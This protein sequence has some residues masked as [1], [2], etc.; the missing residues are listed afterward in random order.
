MG[1][2]ESAPRALRSLRPAVAPSAGVDMSDKSSRT[3]TLDVVQRAT[4]SKR[5][6][7]LARAI[8]QAGLGQFLRGQGPFTIFAPT[9]EA[10]GKLPADKREALLGDRTWLA[11]VVAHH[12][13]TTRVKAPRR[14]ASR[15]A[16]PMYGRELTI[17][18]GVDA[19]TVDDARLV[20]TGIRATNGVIHAIDTVLMPR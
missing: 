4:A 1:I 15:T 19:F 5:F 9:D 18:R 6:T 13:V 8:R 14:G 16:M 2:F 20:K 7:V 11:E 3:P 10:F 12:V 17:A